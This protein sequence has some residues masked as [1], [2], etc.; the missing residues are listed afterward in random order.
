M[1]ISQNHNT[2]KRHKQKKVNTYLNNDTLKQ[3]YLPLK[4]KD[5]KPEAKR[6]STENEPILE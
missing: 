5:K 4:E 3:T 6:I 1:L 2:L